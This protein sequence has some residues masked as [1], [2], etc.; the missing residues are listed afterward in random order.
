MLYLKSQTKKAVILYDSIYM[1][2]QNRQIH[3]KIT[4]AVSGA[5]RKGKWR[6]PA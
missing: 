5:G 6:V 2:V 1:F 4:E 3:R